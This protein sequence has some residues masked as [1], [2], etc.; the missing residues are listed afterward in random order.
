MSEESRVV[1]DLL[2]L[3][4]LDDLQQK[5]RIELLEDAIHR[6]NYEKRFATLNEKQL[7]HLN[8]TMTKET[9]EYLNGLDKEKR[10]NAFEQHARAL[11]F[12]ECAWI[13]YLNGFSNEIPC[14]DGEQS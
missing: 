7:S 14:G 9:R 8:G 6:L 5:E 11:S 1:S 13:N 4:I 12:R 3:D 2:C 10:E